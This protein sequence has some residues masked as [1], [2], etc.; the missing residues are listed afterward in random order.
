MPQFQ[1]FLALGLNL[2]AEGPQLRQYQG[3]RLGAGGRA[4]RQ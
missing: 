1:Q 3:K 4:A 2:Y